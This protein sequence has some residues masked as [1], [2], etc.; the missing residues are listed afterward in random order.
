MPLAISHTP[1][2]TLLTNA[3]TRRV[4][5]LSELVS[6]LCHQLGEAEKGVSLGMCYRGREGN[7]NCGDW[8]GMEIV[9]MGMERR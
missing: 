5:F 9:V 3:S 6:Y 7:G 8:E 2:L 4:Q 1:I